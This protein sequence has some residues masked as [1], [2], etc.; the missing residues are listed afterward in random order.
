MTPVFIEQ[1]S[2][3]DLVIQDAQYIEDGPYIKVVKGKF[4]HWEIT[5]Y[6]GGETMR[7]EFDTYNECRQRLFNET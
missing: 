2:N 4:Q 6:G 7:G 3:G 5:Q 1:D